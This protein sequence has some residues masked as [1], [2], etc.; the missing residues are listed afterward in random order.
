M[1][2]KTSTYFCK[3]KTSTQVKWLPKVTQLVTVRIGTG[4][5]TLVSQSGVMGGT[6][7][8]VKAI[9]KKAIHL[10][11]QLFHLDTTFY[12]IDQDSALPFTC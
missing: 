2:I 1:Q 6:Q 7:Y 11:R 5:G 12:R 8:N 9:F 3:Q 10:H 4:T